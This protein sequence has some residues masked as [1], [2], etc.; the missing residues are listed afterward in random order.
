VVP[1][2]AGRLEKVKMGVEF[3][4]WGGGEG[5]K[6]HLA[7]GAFRLGGFVYLVMNLGLT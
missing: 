2:V 1:T 4:L 5:S 6:F 3:K 7:Q